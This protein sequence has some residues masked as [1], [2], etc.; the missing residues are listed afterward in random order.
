M[1]TGIQDDTVV[2]G[3]VDRYLDGTIQWTFVSLT[4]DLWPV[5]EINPHDAGFSIWERS[6]D[7]GG[8]YLRFFPP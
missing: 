3:H 6:M 4:F 1:I 2:D 8:R 7:V 5:T